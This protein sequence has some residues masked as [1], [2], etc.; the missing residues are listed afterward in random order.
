MHQSAP[1]REFTSPPQHVSSITTSPNGLPAARLSTLESNDTPGSKT[2]E[3]AAQS[4]REMPLRERLLSIEEEESSHMSN[5]S[6]VG[7]LDDSPALS[8]QQQ[9]PADFR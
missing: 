3:V 5:A 9:A 8:Q 1:I 2:S 6:G 4:T 7:V